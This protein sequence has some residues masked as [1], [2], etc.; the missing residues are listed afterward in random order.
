MNTRINK[1]KKI[2]VIGCGYWGTI[3]TKSLIN[4]GYKNIY[5]FDSTFGNALTLKKKFKQISIIKDYRQMLINP[6]IESLFYATPP[7][8]NFKLIKSALKY[9]KKIFLE[10]PGV[11]TSSDFKKLIRINKIYKRKIMV[12][13]VYCFNNFIQYIKEVL[14]KKKLGKILYVNFQR[15]NL[16][17]IRNDVD[18]TYDLSSHDLS[19]ILY[20][21]KKIPKKLSH[22]NY[23]I[24]NKK[25]SDISN[26]HLKLGNIFID[27]NCSWLNPTK[28]R[29]IIIIGSKKMLLFDEMNLEEPIKI[30]NKYAKYPK[31]HEF[32]K[33]F[34][35]SKALIYLGKNFSPRI[36]SS[37]ALSNEINYFAKLNKKNKP[38]TDLSF[39]YKIL[40]FLE[41]I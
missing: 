19:I 31:I 21:F 9:D 20:L 29:K 6:E 26:L 22:I 17:P 28:V 30:Y 15:Q 5:V 32:K 37:P 25:I 3:I 39:S 38:I 23:P 34:F 27:I 8:K 11:I 33:K 41:T 12:G 18:V 35:E 36:K 10:K 4:L 16:G 14:V 24:L 13:Y 40:K 7:S 1:T 2:G